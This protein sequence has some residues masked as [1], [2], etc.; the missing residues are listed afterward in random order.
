MPSARRHQFIRRFDHDTS[1]YITVCVY[2]ILVIC[3]SMI[4]TNLYYTHCAP[5][6]GDLS[7]ALRQLLHLIGGQADDVRDA[8]HSRGHLGASK[9][10]FGM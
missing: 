1:L 9:R 3:I 5:G 6:H 10:R 8:G 7:L 4:D 2:M